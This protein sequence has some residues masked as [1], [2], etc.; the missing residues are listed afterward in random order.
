[1]GQILLPKQNFVMSGIVLYF[2]NRFNI[3]LDRRQLDPPV[4][5]LEL[6]RYHIS[7]S[8]CQS[9]VYSW[10]NKHVQG[11][12]WLMII[13]KIFFYTVDPLHMSQ[14]C[15]V[16]WG[17]WERLQESNISLPCWFSAS[18][19]YVQCYPRSLSWES[20]HL[21]TWFVQWFFSKS[22]KHQGSETWELSKFFSPLCL[23]VIDDGK[24]QR[25]PSQLDTLAYPDLR[26]YLFSAMLRFLVEVIWFISSAIFNLMLGNNGMR[27]WMKPFMGKKK[28]DITEIITETNYWVRPGVMFCT[29]LRTFQLL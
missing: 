12:K 9:T 3:W 7:C 2:A 5:S 1:M 21:L 24:L 19:L 25:E 16:V 4:C 29:F 10:E 11:T 6:L 15:C 28:K 18:R 23:R 14:G 22:I 13:R 26:P 27:L 8:F 17:L 20:L